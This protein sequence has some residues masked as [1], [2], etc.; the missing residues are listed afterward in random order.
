MA[1]ERETTMRLSL[2]RQRAI[3]E[4][5]AEEAADELV[6]VLRSRRDG[7]IELGAHRAF[8]TVGVHEYG[9]STYWINDERLLEETLA[10]LAD[11]IFYRQI[12]VARR[13]GLLD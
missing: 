8:D 10:E 11:A 5:C 1:S 12:A 9:D 6:E 7:L 13:R 3:Y 2:Q 4:R